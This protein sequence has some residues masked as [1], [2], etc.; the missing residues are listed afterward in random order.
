MSDARD[1]SLEEMRR[2]HPYTLV[3]RFLISAPAL[4]IIL[5]PTLRNPDAG[6]WLSV[7]TLLL[8]GIFIV[9]LFVAQYLRFRYA[10]TPDEIVIHKGVFTYQHRNIPIERIQNIEI[11][12]S[13]IPRLFGTASIKIETAGSRSTEGVIEY[14]GLDEAHRLRATVRARQQARSGADDARSGDGI[15]DQPDIRPDN[16]TV[17]PANDGP[18]SPTAAYDVPASAAARDSDARTTPGPIHGASRTGAATSARHDLDDAGDTG[19]MIHE[20]NVGHVL[21][22]GVFRF[23][24]FYIVAIFSAVEYLG[25]YPEDVARWLTG[26]RFEAV[27]AAFESATWLVILATVFMVTFLAWITGIATNLNRFYGFRLMLDGDKLHTRSGLFTVSEGTIPLKKVQALLL[28]TNPLMS[29]FGWYRLELQ[30]MGFDPNDRGYRVAV[31]FARWPEVM[32][33]ART[34][35][36]VEDPGE[37]ESVSRLMIRRTL[38]RYLAVLVLLAGGIG[39]FWEPALWGF[40]ALPAVV[41]LAIQQYRHH[42]YRITDDYLYVRRGVF[43]ESYWIIPVDRFQVFYLTQSLFQRRLG[44]KS[45]YVDTP[46]AGVLMHPVIEDL[47]SDDASRILRILHR[48]FH[49]HFHGPPEHPT[50]SG[51]VS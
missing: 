10:V 3:Q 31:P 44:L 7:G 28:R 40:I 42:G 45:A 26:D 34:I 17:R 6:T 22:S 29:A 13:L 37:L 14:V 16:S 23:S 25:V 8:Y 27:A 50:D 24:L 46:G 38:V 5:L 2:L 4:L 21:L 11:E 18:A 51:P 9:P 30:T 47:A 35:R 43:R 36:P 12:Q 49:D 20:M 39:Y 19:Q 48:R 41:L 15:D 33:I 1:V 32:E